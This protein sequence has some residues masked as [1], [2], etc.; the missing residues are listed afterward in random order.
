LAYCKECGARL[1]DGFE[2]CP[3]C[4]ASARAPRRK[5]PRDD[6]WDIYED[7]GCKG[8]SAAYQRQRMER[9]E[10]TA[11]EWDAEPIYDAELVDET[12]DGASRLLAAVSYV[13]WLFILPFLLKKDD[14]FVKSHLNQGMVLFII[15]FCAGMLGFLGVLVNLVVL[16]MC[17]AGFISALRGKYCRL[18]LVSDINII[19]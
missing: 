19:K 2:K 15:S 8:G 6:S 16:F 5:K 17:L 9:E 1:A 10:F 12:P 14:P 4:G 3:A 11:E 7:N 18:P 13:R